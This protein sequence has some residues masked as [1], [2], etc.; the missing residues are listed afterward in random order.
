MKYVQQNKVM[1]QCKHTGFASNLQESVTDQIVL[2]RTGIGGMEMI[3]NRNYHVDKQIK[4]SFYRYFNPEQP[5]KWELAQEGEDQC[6]ICCKHLLTYIF[7]N[8]HDVSKNKDL[9]EVTDA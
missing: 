2:M 3:F 7:F 1:N 8:Q 6:T 5:L 4:G 9:I